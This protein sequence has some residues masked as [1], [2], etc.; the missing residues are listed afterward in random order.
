MLVLTII[1]TILILVILGILIYYVVQNKDKTDC[2]G[3]DKAIE[4][5][6]KNGNVMD[7]NNVKENLQID[8]PENMNFRGVNTYEQMQYA[9]PELKN[10]S[11]AMV[12]SPKPTQIEEDENNYQN[13]VTDIDS[14]GRLGD[15]E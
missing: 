9:K 7:A 12:Q 14:A 3:T 13:K 4:N 11:Y 15:Y 10:V 6:I 1:N 5:I 2:S 8:E